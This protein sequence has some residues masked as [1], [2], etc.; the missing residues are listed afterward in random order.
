M[1]TT[2]TATAEECYPE[3]FVLRR[4]SSVMFYVHVTSHP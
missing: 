1:M 2:I 3:T 4:F